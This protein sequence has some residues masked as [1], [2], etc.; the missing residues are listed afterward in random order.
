M[1]ILI[2]IE[3]PAWAH[4]FRHFISE[5]E[6]K[7]HTIKVVA[8]KKDVDLQLLDLFNIEYEV[9][10]NSSGNNIFE[11]GL[12]FLKATYNIFKI[13]LKFKPDIYVGR[14]SPMV[15]INGFLFHKKNIRYEDSERISFLLFFNRLF[16]DIVMTPMSFNKSLGKTQLKIAAY[17]ELFYLHPNWFQPNPEV[18]TEL[19]L[20]AN[21]KFA[22]LRFVAWKAHHDI[23][24]HGISNKKEFVKELE[25]YGRVFISAEGKLDKELEKYK[26]NISPEKMHDLMFYAHM[27]V[28]DSQTMTTEAAILGTPAIRCN[29]FVGNNDM[30]NFTDLEEKYGLI[31]NYSDQEKALNKA[32]ELFQAPNLKNEWK[33]KR[34]QLLEDKIDA[35]KFMVWFVENYPESFE[36]MKQNPELQYKFK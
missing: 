16:S 12:I 21:D 30:S 27:I 35:T 11:K 20:G 6:K 7:G 2:S 5:M 15:A 4:Q 34:S 14:T 24:Q 9:I 1:K 3:H 28:G 23:G 22:I 29:T 18:L 36:M 13:S 26:L 17:K 32:V 31:F 25:K 33:I 19:N 10:S 8:I